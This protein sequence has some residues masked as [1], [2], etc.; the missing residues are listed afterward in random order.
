MKLISHADRQKK[1]GME[2]DINLPQT[3][4][5]QG[6]QETVSDEQILLILTSRLKKSQKQYQK[7]KIFAFPFVASKYYN[8]SLVGNQGIYQQCV[9]Q[10][11]CQP[12]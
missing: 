3:F 9:L 10:T 4:G 7:S 8:K 6:Y 11:K 2:G 1:G 5:Y 12:V